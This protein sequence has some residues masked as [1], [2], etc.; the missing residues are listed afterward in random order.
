[1]KLL[2]HKAIDEINQVIK[3]EMKNLDDVETKM[4]IKKDGW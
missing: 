3:D 2:I 1:M 4:L